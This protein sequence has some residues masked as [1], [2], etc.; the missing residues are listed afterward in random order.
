ML[1]YAACL[2]IEWSAFVFIGYN[3]F[4]LLLF[5]CW[6][7]VIVPFRSF[8]DRTSWGSHLLTTPTDCF[9]WYVVGCFGEQA[10]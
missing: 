4:V 3:S 8:N 10:R 6:F 1:T 7:L 2:L 5:F 9:D